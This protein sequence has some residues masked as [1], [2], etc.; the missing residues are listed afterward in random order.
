MQFDNDKALKNLV[1]SMRASLKAE[2]GIDVPYTALRASLLRAQGENPHAQGKKATGGPSGPDHEELLELVKEA[3]LYFH[4]GYDFDGD[5]L[6]WLQRAGHVPATA[7]NV[8]R[9]PSASA[10]L[11]ELF[12]LQGDDGEWTRLALDFEGEFLL[13]ADWRFESAALV[14]Q[15][16]VVP[17]KLGTRLV[18]EI[19]NLREPESF[20]RTAFGLPLDPKRYHDAFRNLVPESDEPTQFRLQVRMPAHEWSRLLLAVLHN[21]EFG[22][23]RDQLAEW[24]GQHHRK[25]LDAESAENQAYWLARYVGCHETPV[26][27]ME[28]A[29]V[30]FEWLWPDQESESVPAVIDLETG[31]LTVLGKVPADTLSTD[32]ITRVVMDDADDTYEAWPAF[33]DCTRHWEIHPKVLPEIRRMFL[34]A[35]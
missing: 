23:L 12:V 11:R 18:R 9:I 34:Q 6:R 2:H 13:P 10:G 8:A 16:V 4:P 15:M 17:H 26:D 3:P 32:V 7:Q 33:D 28:T 29:Q 35:A 14:R 31:V 30:R 24:L 25:N 19:A 22:N 20:Y 21:T 27:A 5:K 1:R